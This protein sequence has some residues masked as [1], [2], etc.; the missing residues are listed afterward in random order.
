M[1]EITKYLDF[2]RLKPYNPSQTKCQP[3]KKNDGTYTNGHFSSFVSGLCFDIRSNDKT[4]LVSSRLYYRY[5]YY[6]FLVIYVVLMKVLFMDVRLYIMKNI[7][8]LT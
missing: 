3:L 5:K 2:M 4:M 8:T 1:T 6:Q 7:W